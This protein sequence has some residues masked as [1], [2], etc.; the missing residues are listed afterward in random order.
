MLRDKAL[1]KTGPEGPED[2]A[3]SLTRWILRQA[4]HCGLAEGCLRS[5]LG[6]LSGDAEFSKK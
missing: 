5:A 4:Q 6:Y 3:G 2:S 1:P